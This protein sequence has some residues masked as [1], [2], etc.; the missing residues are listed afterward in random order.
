MLGKFG[1]KIPIA[2]LGGPDP[3]K[4]ELSPKEKAKHRMC[5]GMVPPPIRLRKK[6]PEM[7]VVVLCQ[8][9]GRKLLEC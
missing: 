5:H 6:C 1:R 8:K 2:M 7:W 9:I 3:K 4:T